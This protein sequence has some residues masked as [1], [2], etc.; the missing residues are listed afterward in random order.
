MAARDILRKYHTKKPLIHARIHDRI[1]DRIHLGN[2][3]FIDQ[4]IYQLY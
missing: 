4:L 1:H 2:A 3:L